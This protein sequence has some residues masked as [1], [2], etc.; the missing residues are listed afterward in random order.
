MFLEDRD[1]L[2]EIFK[3]STNADVRLIV[4]TDRSGVL[5]IG[6]KV[7]AAWV[8]QLLS[9]FCIQRLVA[10]V[11]ITLP[12]LIDVGT[13]NPVLLNDPLY[14]GWRHPRVDNESYRA[15]I[16]KIIETIE[17]ISDVFVHWRIFPRRMLIPY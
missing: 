9:S 17:V 1:S 12:V 4:I 6:I 16:S 7:W 5:G 3:N 14:L 13:D 15:F 10:S 2:A 11:H 8:S